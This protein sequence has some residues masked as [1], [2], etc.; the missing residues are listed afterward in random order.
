MNSMNFDALATLKLVIDQ[1]NTFDQVIRQLQAQINELSS[2]I[3]TSMSTESASSINQEEVANI[4]ITA[5]KFKKLSDSLMFNKDQ[6]KLHFF[7]TKLHLKFFENADQ[8]LTD[9]NKINYVMF[10]LK[11]DAVCTMNFFF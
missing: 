7:I 1:L 5:A 11:N 2:Q 8:F 6:K 4:T 10:Y 3:P 9:R